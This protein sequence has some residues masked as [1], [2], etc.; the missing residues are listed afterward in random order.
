MALE[1][2]NR[3]SESMVRRFGVVCLVVRVSGRRLKVCSLVFMR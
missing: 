3:G 1:F 2:N